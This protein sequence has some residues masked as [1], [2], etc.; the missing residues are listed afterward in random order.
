MPSDKKKNP[1]LG[2][3]TEAFNE[4]YISSMSYLLEYRGFMSLPF[5]NDPIKESQKFSNRKVFDTYPIY[6]KHTVF[7]DDENMKK[8]RALEVS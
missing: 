5:S 3:L 8:V 7:H 4:E 6:L 1:S 2:P